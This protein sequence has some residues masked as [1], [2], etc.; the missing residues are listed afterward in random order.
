MPVY[1]LLAAAVMIACVLLNRLSS[2]L[3]IPMLLAFIL[4]GMFFGTDGIV[5][6]PFENYTFAEQAC[7]VALIFI[8]FY[9]GF[10]TNWKKARPVAVKAGLLSTA[11]VVL[12]A[13]LTGMFCHYVLRIAWMESLLLGSVIGSTDAASVFS[14]LRAKRL[15]LKD[16]TASLLEVESGSNDPCAYMLTMVVISAMQGAASGGGLAWMVF[17]QLVFGAGGGVVIAL[18]ALAVMKRIKTVT[19]GFDTVLVVAIAVLAYAAPVLAGGNGYLSVYIV[20]IVLGNAKLENK[21]QL[22]HFFD[23][24][25][26][27]MQM[28]LFFLLG[29]LSFPSRL[30]AIVLPALAI[31]L[32]LTFAARPIAVFLL[33]SP[34]KSSFRQQLV[35]SWAG[36]RGAASIVF[37]ITAQIAVKTE[38]DI[39][40]IVFFIVLFS[41]LIQGALLP[42]VSKKAGMLDEDGDV[43]KTFTDY[44]EEIP[45]QFIQCTIAKGHPWCGEKLKDVLL[46]PDSIAALLQRQDKKIVPVGGTVLAEG[47]K[48][49]LCAESPVG[50]EGVCLFERPILKDDDWLGKT[51]A[52]IQG[53]DTQLV[54][55]IQRAGRVIIPRGNARIKENDIL[56]INRFETT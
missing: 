51:L 22:V 23:G 54:V 21:K 50:V 26:G 46:P 1:L 10:G 43:M 6:I 45:V 31:A 9:G 20:G 18:L 44:S 16:N 12:T 19:A 42:L 39:F 32:F 41:I 40:H 27:L 4:L 17:A 37:A 3:G 29:L 7:S 25:T 8:M 53:P 35:V 15:N 13:V 2:K 11:G 38:N 33:L 14:I 36:L 55:M 28:L 24:L 30:P 47:D 56:V 52:E 5:K 49:I 34:L 48:L